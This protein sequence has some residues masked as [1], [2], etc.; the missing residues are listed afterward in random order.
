QLGF[1][2]EE[3]ATMAAAEQTGIYTGPPADEWEA[4]SRDLPTTRAVVADTG[5]PRPAP[6]ARQPG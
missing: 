6:R 4:A 5:V 2:R 3:Q 1:L